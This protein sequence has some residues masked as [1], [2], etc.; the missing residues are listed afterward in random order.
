MSKR[1]IEYCQQF[2]H[3]ATDKE[4]IRHYII[5]NNLETEYISMITDLAASQQ[6]KLTVRRNHTNFIL[7]S[8]SGTLEHLLKT[9]P[10]DVALLLLDLEL[11]YAKTFDFDPRLVEKA[12]EIIPTIDGPKAYYNDVVT[13]L[14]KKYGIRFKNHRENIHEEY[15]SRRRELEDENI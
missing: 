15:I 9:Y 10:R 13:H 6:N 11:S 12:K 14:N 3:L 7:D 1:L 5:S 2:G 8:V 4:I